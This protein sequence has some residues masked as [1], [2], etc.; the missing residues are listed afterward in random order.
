[1]KT[2]C[3]VK[4]E[5]DDFFGNAK[6]LIHLDAADIYFLYTKITNRIDQTLSIQDIE[7]FLKLLKSRRT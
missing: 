7:N 6:D 5:L 2:F 4:R 1:M 3:E